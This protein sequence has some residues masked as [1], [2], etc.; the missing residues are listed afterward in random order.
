M[1]YERIHMNE[2]KQDFAELFCRQ[3]GRVGNP[4]YGKLFSREDC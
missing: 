3:H 2:D 1:P 4:P